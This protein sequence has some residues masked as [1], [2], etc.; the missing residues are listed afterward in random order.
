MH[1]TDEN[2]N[3][4]AKGRRLAL[5]MAGVG[6]FWILVTEIGRQY[7]W[8]PTLRIAFDLIVLVGFGYGLWQGLKLWQNRRADE[9]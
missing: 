2:A 8:S 9:D 7:G 1:V 5:F 4:G 3:S 6:V